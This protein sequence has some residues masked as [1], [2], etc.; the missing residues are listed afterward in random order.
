[1]ESTSGLKKE[2]KDK[3]TKKKSQKAKKQ[4]EKKQSSE[5]G[6]VKV[7]YD[8]G[9]TFASN[10]VKSVVYLAFVLVISLILSYCAIVFANEVF[11]F[12]KDD[13]EV[14]VNIG[15]YADIRAISEE[16]KAKGV[17]KYDGVF[18]LY[19]KL[20]HYDNYTFVPGEYTVSCALGYDKL[21]GLFVEKKPERESVR[22]TI[23]EG[24]CCDD[25]IDLMLSKG[26]GTRDGWVRALN[27]V[28]YDYWF[29]TDLEVEDGRHYR[30]EGYLYPDTYYFWSDS[31][32]S[33]AITKMLDNFQSKFKKKY[34][35]RVNELNMTLDEV[36]KL[37]S[38][39]EKEG[40]FDAEYPTISSV[41]SNRLKS[42]SMTKLQSEA[43]VAYA[44]RHIEGARREVA[45]EDVNLVD[46]YNTYYCDGLPVG[47]ICNPTIDSISAAMYPEKTDYYYF[48]ADIDGHSLFAKT[49]DE[50]RANIEIVEKNREAARKE[51]EN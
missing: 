20:R 15:E 26:I 33:V 19:S 28:E 4:K 29:L 30:L 8:R 9:G 21:V 6:E 10:I 3:V 14:S 49:M 37:A 34:M 50:H 5:Q 22:V 27:E 40:K 7:V 16:L 48:V 31:K 1:M 41:F 51:K 39:I 23:P 47:P 38:I 17:I 24:Y 25:I 18:R 2:S 45:D 11:A 32:E 43:T 44:I 46:P 13:T 36:L 12:R 42:K 35:D